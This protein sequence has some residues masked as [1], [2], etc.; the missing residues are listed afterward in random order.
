MKTFSRRPLLAICATA[1]LVACGKDLETGPSGGGGGANVG[2]EGASTS[3]QNAMGGNGGAPSNVC[4]LDKSKLD[5]CVL[6]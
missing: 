2:G 6:Q 1:A 5:Q 4:V 3:T